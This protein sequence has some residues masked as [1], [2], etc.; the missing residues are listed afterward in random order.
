MKTP[1]LMLVFAIAVT[2]QSHSVPCG[3]ST[4]VAADSGLPG[5]P[6]SVAAKPGV[7]AGNIAAQIRQRPPLPVRPSPTCRCG[8]V[9]ASSLTAASDSQEVPIL[10]RLAGSFRFDHVLV[11]ETER[12]ASDTAGSLTVGVG[13][14]N[15]GADVVAP[16]PLMSESAPYHVWY[17]RP[18]PPQL[19]GTYDLVLNFNASS[20]VGDGFASNFRSGMVTWEVCGYDVPPAPAR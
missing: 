8:T 3:T 20:R 11:Q 1:L 16:F 19:T 6:A 15:L 13:R 9:A 2:A 18:V 14:P 17:E 7:A 4:T 5:S 10:T 12:F